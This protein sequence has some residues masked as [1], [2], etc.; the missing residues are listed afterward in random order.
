MIRKILGYLGMVAVAG[1]LAQTMVTT[2]YLA[3]IDHGL[4]SSLKSTKDLI[5]IQNSIVHKN[6]ALQGVVN[7]TQDMAGRLD[8]TLQETNMIDQHIHMINALNAQTLAIN[9]GLVTIGNQSG[10]TLSNVANNM[11]QLSQE[12][13][14]LNNSI[15]RLD[16]LIQQ[17]RANM[18]RMKAYADQMNSKTPGVG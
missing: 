5:Q 14:G 6:Q 3:Q 10:Q 12:T 4:N 18:D 11:Q 16:Q 2:Y 1:V 15:T 13:A 8:A 9:H 17:D 7:T